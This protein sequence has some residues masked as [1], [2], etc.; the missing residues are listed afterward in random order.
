MAKVTKIFMWLS[1]VLG[2][3]GALAP[4]GFFV[5]DKVSYM[6][7]MNASTNEV[8]PAANETPTDEIVDFFTYTEASTSDANNEDFDM[9]SI[10]EVPTSDG[11]EKLS[12]DLGPE[13][14]RSNPLTGWQAFWSVSAGYVVA[15][16]IALPT[17]GGL[18]WLIYLILAG[19]KALVAAVKREQNTRSKL[20]D[21]RQRII[22]WAMAIVLTVISLAHGIRFSYRQDSIW[23][24]AIIPVLVIGAATFLHVMRRRE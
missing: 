5:A 18:P 2:I 19:V 24:L 13:P 17:A 9:L 16:A 11:N 22:V 10:P 15:S 12:W 1:I 23:W 4:W 14:L 20:L 7:Y 8:S 21:V 6:N 3:T